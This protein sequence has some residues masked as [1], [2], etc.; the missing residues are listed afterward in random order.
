MAIIL[1]GVFIFMAI[2]IVAIIVYVNV[3]EN[4]RE[5]GRWETRMAYER[6]N[7]DEVEPLCLYKSP[8][9]YSAPADDYEEGAA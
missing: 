1:E 3:Y 4:G 6:Q 8:Q 9:I 5:K 2:S 7:Q